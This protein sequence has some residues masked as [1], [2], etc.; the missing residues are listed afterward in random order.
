MDGFIV[1]KLRVT[2]LVDIKS[3]RISRIAGGLVYI[4]SFHQNLMN[5]IFLRI[6][7]LFYCVELSKKLQKKKCRWEYSL[8]K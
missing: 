1:L 8:S 3:K 2:K 5:A 7:G 6:Y 4:F